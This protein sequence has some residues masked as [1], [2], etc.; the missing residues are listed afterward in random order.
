MERET[1]RATRVSVVVPARDV[2]ATIAQTLESLLAQTSDEWEAV[3][4]DDGSGD[5]TAR[6]VAGFADR[7]ARIRLVAGSGKGVSSAR[8]AGIAA[9]R[10][11]WLLF[12]DADDWIHPTYF[13]HVGEAL[14]ED[15]GLDA[16]TCGCA[17][18]T[19]TGE[20]GPD[21]FPP[22][23][24]ALFAALGRDCTFD[25][26][27]C[28]VRRALVEAVGCFDTT[29]R[30]CEDWDLW[31]RVARAGARFGQVP[32]V[33]AYYR[34]RAGSAS[35][36]AERLHAD[37]VEVAGRTHRPDPRVPDP[38]P[39]FAGGLPRERLL[40]ALF[41]STSYCAGMLLVQGRDPRGLLEPLPPGREPTLDPVWVADSIRHGLL[42]ANQTL[43]GGLLS[44]WPGIEPDLGN[45]LDLLEA[46]S[47]AAALSRR[48][49]RALERLV[50]ED[51]D[52]PRPATVGR[53]AALRVEVTEPVEDVVA[54]GCERLVCDVLVEG[55]FL[56]T[57]ELPV[58]DGRVPGPVLAD[59]IADELF[60]P[61]LKAFFER[62]VP[63]YPAEDHDRV[64]WEVMLQELWDRPEWSIEQFYNPETA[65]VPAGGRAPAAVPPVV[66]ISDDLPSFVTSE[67]WLEL[68]ATVGG[69]PLGT[70]AVGARAS[71]VSTQAVRSAIMFAG[72]V[73]IAR[74]A[75]RA[76][77]I[78]RPLSSG[79]SL[80]GRLAEAAASGC[81]NGWSDAHALVLC[82]RSPH[83][84]GTSASRRAA[85][86]AATATLLLESAA[87]LGEPAREP[88]NGRVAAAFYAPDQIVPNGHPAAAREAPSG[89]AP[90]RLSGPRR[91]RRR[92]RRWR[93]ARALVAAARRP[94]EAGRIHGRHEF[95]TLFARKRD[96]WV[97][98]SPYEQT[99]YEQTLELIPQGPFAS[100]LELGCAEGQ[101]T[102]ML[103]RR[104][105]HLVAADISE[106]ALRRARSRCAEWSNVDYLQLDLVTDAVPGTYDLVVCSEVL[107]YVGDRKSLTAVARRLARLIA[108][109]GYLVTAHAHV[110]TDDPDS[111]GYAWGVP[112]GAKAI[113]EELARTGKLRLVKELRTPLYRIQLFERGRGLR[114]G[115][116][117][118]AEIVELPQPAPVPEQAAP[119]VRWLGA[120][121]AEPD[122]VQTEALP[123]L[124]YH[125]IAEDGP[126][127]TERYR[128]APRAFQE[129]LRYLWN[130]G[131]R[132]V[133][134]AEWREALHRR[135]PLPG[136]C[137]LLTFDDG[138]RDF[139]ANAWPLL[140]RYG[141]RA[142]VFL[143]ADEIGGVNRWDRAYGHEVEL[144]AWDEIR[145]LRAGGI[146][147]GS[148]TASHPPLTGLTPED[149]VREAARS[150]AILSRGLG[151]PVDAFAYPYGDLDDAV[152]RLVGATGYTYGLTCNAELSKYDDDL[153]ALPRIEIMGSD[154]LSTFILRLAG[155]A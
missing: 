62:T 139:L 26:H 151:V 33:L 47:G 42:F 69:S 79:P 110:V 40:D 68:V 72:G 150:R 12:L 83:T 22:D 153:L 95:E 112:F 141:L 77:L 73:E 15:P 18:V 52:V 81:D 5:A 125:R 41:N 113:G 58:C 114:V 123:I 50:L 93:R 129:Q 16:V 154:D 116:N 80:R 70:V 7:D 135:Q 137:V 106:V 39:R 61:L 38:D 136:R 76:G 51:S 66:E 19:P 3:V 101:F 14:G 65:D 25:I 84:I 24:S 131:F 111:P 31:A 17:F 98:T 104:V 86:P 148:H 8:N 67:P 29:L 28:V 64:G 128:V 11:E 54:P 145:R 155:S 9:A 87:A 37:L 36:S 78:G 35:L 132:S 32:E 1:A 49:V 99:K 92:V 55:E 149:V 122:V 146:E 85:L 127:D 97:Y 96:P 2:E 60:W 94:A 105:D 43:P 48:A 57:L 23:E 56:D 144:L 59:A 30:T 90:R 115:R 4:V 103:A 126:P 34:M 134:L 138:Y 107:Y 89:A 82:R 152:R 91:L 117:G 6:I 75:V 88:L 142:T 21:R 102:A 27:A 45:F 63:G 143:V 109:G 118:R 119:L 147:F 13:A 10:Y 74:A 44:L 120:T 130:A 124:M 133:S 121:D 100:A 108:P 140:E 53:T 46:R 20:V 71:R